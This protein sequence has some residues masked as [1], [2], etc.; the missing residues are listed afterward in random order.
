[1]ASRRNTG[2]EINKM[3][4]TIKIGNISWSEFPR[5]SPLGLHRV[6]VFYWF[7]VCDGLQLWPLHADCLNTERHCKKLHDLYLEYNAQPFYIL[8]PSGLSK[9]CRRPC[10]AFCPSTT[11]TPGPTSIPSCAP[12]W[13]CRRG[14]SSI[15]C[16]IPSIP[17]AIPTP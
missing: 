4:A 3:Y 15:A 8:P 5:Y 14:E 17:V 16:R 9:P 10:R 2:H 11:A 6:I 12:T 7:R 1:M 13:P